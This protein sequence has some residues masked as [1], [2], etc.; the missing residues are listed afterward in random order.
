M[1][2]FK[3]FHLADVKRNLEYVIQ[4]EGCL[5]EVR[6]E[7]LLAGYVFS[8]IERD[9]LILYNPQHPTDYFYYCITVSKEGD[10]VS[11]HLTGKSMQMKIDDY[12]KN[13]IPFG[14]TKKSSAKADI[15]NF[16]VG[17][18]VGGVEAGLTKVGIRGI[19]KGIVALTRDKEVL[20]KEKSWHNEIIEAGL[21]H[22]VR[23][24]F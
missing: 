20:A 24:F 14:G 3:L 8:P 23:K 15:L 16:G 7:K 19:S 18:T 10:I 1:K 17:M 4:R 22:A 13:S 6:Y 11:I 12:L 9:C 21:T 2:P 5:A